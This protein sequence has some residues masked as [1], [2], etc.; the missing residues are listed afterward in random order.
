MTL[1]PVDS[2]EIVPLGDDE[3][4]PPA[5]NPY[6]VYLAR[7]DVGS[8]STMRSAAA[9]AMRT[10]LGL[11]PE[12]EVE[13]ARFPWHRITYP[14]AQRLRSLLVEEDYAPQTVNK[15]L[16]FVRKA[17]RE[18]WLLGLAPYEEVERLR[19]VRN[20]DQT[21]LPAG[22]HVDAAEIARVLASCFDDGTVL[23]LRD[24]ALVGLLAGAGLREMEAARLLAADYDAARGVVRVRCGKRRK[25]R[26]TYLVRSFDDALARL[27]AAVAPAAGDPIV[28]RLAPVGTVLRPLQTVTPQTVNL[29]L[30]RRIAA[31][32]TAPFTPHDLRRTFITNMLDAGHDPL[33]VARMVGHESPRTTMLYDRRTAESDRRA[34]RDG[35]GEGGAR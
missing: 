12:D 11:E 31:A 17:L 21:R 18:A 8:R 13:A 33:R 27:V 14:I 10:L 20:V 32:G 15:V 28:P 25:E 5:R 2:V 24:A 1:A 7:L 29:S 3:V 26:D 22:R 9:T 30:E 35:D 6:C 34:V 16:T 23:G 4:L 19:E